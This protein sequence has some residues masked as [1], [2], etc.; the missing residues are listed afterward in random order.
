MPKLRKPYDSTAAKKLRAY[1]AEHG[2]QHFA[3]QALGLDGAQINRWLYGQIPR[4]K[5]RQVLLDLV[6]ITE[7]DW[8]DGSAFIKVASIDEDPGVTEN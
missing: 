1:T 2:G 8:R 4:P 5:N 6:G 7:E 3:A